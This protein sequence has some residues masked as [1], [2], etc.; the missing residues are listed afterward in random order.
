MYFVY[1][2]GE[3]YITFRSG[4]MGTASGFLALIKNNIELW[5]CNWGYS[6]DIMTVPKTKECTLR[7]LFK[8]SL[9][10]VS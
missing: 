10:C 8:R 1:V 2:G 4:A 7:S 3:T 6:V 5:G 9:P